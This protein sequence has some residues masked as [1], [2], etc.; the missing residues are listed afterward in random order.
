MGNSCNG[1]CILPIPEI[2]F[3]LR[4]FCQNGR[5]R[6]FM[7]CLILPQGLYAHARSDMALLFIHNSQSITI[8]KR[9]IKWKLQKA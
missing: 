4:L 5:Q 6:R 2:S 3:L 9:G 7:H 1:T 8:T